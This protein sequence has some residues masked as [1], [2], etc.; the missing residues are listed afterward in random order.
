MSEDRY[1]L[2]GQIAV[3]GSEDDFMLPTVHPAGPPD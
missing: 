3:D 1:D 2:T